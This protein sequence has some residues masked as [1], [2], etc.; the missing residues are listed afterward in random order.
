M[1]SD[2][3]KLLCDIGELS[4]VFT[5][6]ASIE[7]FLQK[8]VQMVGRHMDA[9]VCSI[10]IYEEDQEQLVLA[11]T[12]GL[13][14]EGIGTVRLHISEG[15]TG[16]ALREARA[17]SEKSGK[18]NPNFKFFAGIYEEHY[19]AFLAVP[20]IRGV[21]KVGVLVAQRGGKRYFSESESMALRAVASQ[22]ANMIE[23]AKLLL[24]IHN[25]PQESASGAK[26][27]AP[28]EIGFVK[29]KAA[30]EGLAFAPAVV[31][32]K[33]R[34]MAV[35]YQKHFDREY[36]LNELNAAIRETESQ[37]EELQK[38]V[39]DKL[40]DVASLIFTAHLLILKDRSFVGTMRDLTV[41][42]VNAAQAV[43]D[44]ARQYT[45][46]FSQS[47]NP[48]LREKVQDVQDLTLRL[49]RNLLTD[50]QQVASYTGKIIIARELFPS[51]LLKMSSEGAA[52]IVLVGGGV[53]S[54]LSILARSLQ[55]PM[56][57]AEKPELL[58]IADNLPVVV[59]AVAGNVYV[60]P[61]ENI[62]SNFRLREQARLHIA[63]QKHP[64]NPQ[65][66][67]KDGH[68][69]HLLSNINL[70]ADVKLARQLP[71]DGIGLY[72]TEFPFMIRSD[73]PSEQ[74][75]YVVYRKLVEQMHGKVITFRTLDMGGDKILSYYQGG[76]EENPFLGMRAIR[77]SLHNTIIFNQQLRAMLRAGDASDLRI[78]FPM[79]S[80]LDEFEQARELV[81]ECIGAMQYEG[82]PHNAKP[83]IGLMIELPS[84][85][86]II[87]DLA[88]SADFL[89]IG[90]NDLVQY[91]LAVDRTNERVANLYQPS[92][93][94][95]LRAIKKVVDAGKKFNK[96]VSICGDMARDEKFLSFLIGIGM[97]HLSVEPAYLLT[98]QKLISELSLEQCAEQA[99]QMLAM[100]RIKN[101]SD[102]ING[103][104]KS[105]TSHHEWK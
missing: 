51:D 36:T 8:V 23:N 68:H 93:P 99:N 45:E 44:V 24:S 69:I 53:T 20:I 80:S 92:H 50:T 70:L 14:P 83:M 21:N 104:T 25:I 89:S 94:A 34:L 10:Y 78:M 105:Q 66:F 90:T 2:H 59:D 30:S 54:H 72:R 101:V 22:L 43:L 49:M 27:V 55:I 3:I 100:S 46:I 48:L 40:S 62:L 5:D 73:F 85:I 38:Q 102:M 71:C 63:Q 76:K 42:G 81:I 33:N 15:L 17:V 18:D 91:M 65:T 13:N 67:T 32:D 7:S 77:F 47:A 84:V 9:D 61:P 98:M 96:P 39:E 35:L 29:G 95:V 79:V 28:V 6:S 74:E 16:Q 82:L 58:S 57:I 88:Q 11:A 26:I 19:D 56:V 12:Q 1:A 4:W 64:S 97:T 31:V 75:Q 60:D 103:S 87:D 37:L 86:D 52:G 41:E